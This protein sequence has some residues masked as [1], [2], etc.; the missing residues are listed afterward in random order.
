MTHALQPSHTDACRGPYIEDD[1]TAALSDKCFKSGN[2][3]EIE[4]MTTK[5]AFFALK[6]EIW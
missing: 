5:A 6:K 2:N 1:N 3:F 4:L